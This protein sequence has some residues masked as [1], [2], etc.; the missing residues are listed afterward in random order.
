[1]RQTWCDLLFMHWPLPYDTL[2]AVVPEALPLD[3]FDG[4]AWIGVVPFHMRG[5]RP[6]WAPPL[7]WLSAF[8][9]LNVRTY[10][11]LDGKPGIWFFSLDAGNPVAV[12]VARRWFKLPYFN[13]RMTCVQRGGWIEYGCR[14]VHA[15]A[16]PAALSMR[17]RPRGELFVAAPGT[18]EYFLTARYCLYTVEPGDAVRRL[19]IDHVPWPLQPAEAEVA[20]NTMTEQ[21]GIRL[22]GTPPLLHFAR[23][24]DM[25]AWPRQRVGRSTPNRHQSR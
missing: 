25:V 2:R 10:V 22:P 9:E 15:G 11:S 3:T 4:A 7:P 13:A 6:R 12:E 23:R 24:V 18:L 5:V 19:E 1:M 14:R 21:L 8:P 16:P 17:Y 20:V